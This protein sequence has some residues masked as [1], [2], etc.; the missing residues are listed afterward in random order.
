MA[1]TKTYIVNDQAT[2]AD[3]LDFKSYVETLVDIIKTGN[4]PLAID[5]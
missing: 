5:V 4:T 3:A 2:E 1:E